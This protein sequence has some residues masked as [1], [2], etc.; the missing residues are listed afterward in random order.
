MSSKIIRQEQAEQKEIATFTLSVASQSE[1]VVPSHEMQPTAPRGVETTPTPEFREQL[2]AQ[3]NRARQEAELIVRQ[4]QSHA[5]EIEK[6][7]YEKGFQGGERSGRDTGKEMSEAILKQYAVRLEELAQ[8]RKQL[9]VG[10]ERDVMRLALEIAKKVVKRE[11]TIDEELIL[12]MVKVAVNRLA[13]QT[14][15]TIRLNPKDFQVMQAQQNSRSI[16]GPG[17]EGIKLVEDSLISRGGCL[18]ETESGTIDSR[19][20]EQFKEIERGLFD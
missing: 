16:L 10:A 4:A 9:L 8:V 7:A 3:L 2:E 15:V 17:N 1:V 6:E 20:E 12:T 5:S 14:A 13:E 11:V 19:I 18:I